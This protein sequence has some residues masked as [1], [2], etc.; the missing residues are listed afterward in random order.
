VFFSTDVSDLEPAAP[1]ATNACGGEV[2]LT[3]E[4]SA[5]Q[6]GDRCGA[7][8]DGFLTCNGVDALRCIAATPPNPCGGCGNL[9]FEPYDACGACGDGFYVCNGANGLICEAASAPNACGGCGA[10]DGAPGYPCNANALANWACVSPSEVV[11]TDGDVNPCGG[12][13]PLTFNGEEALPGDSCAGACR[14]GVLQCDGPESLVC[15]GAVAENACGG[16]SV[17]PGEL[18]ESCGP[19]G[20]Q[21]AC[22]EDGSYVCD[23]ITPN[24]CGGCESLSLQPGQACGT[25]G[26]TVCNSVD[27]VACDGGGGDSNACGGLERLD[28]TPGGVCG[29]CDSGTWV[30]TSTSTVECVGAGTVNPCFGCLPL[31]GDPGAPCGPCGSG[32]WSCDGEESVT[33]VGAAEAAADEENTCGGCGTLPGTLG[34]ECGVCHTYACFG[35]A[36]LQC[37]FDPTDVCTGGVTCDELGCERVFRECVEDVVE[38]GATASY[39]GQ[40]IDGYVEV[41]GECVPDQVC[42]SDAECPDPVVSQWS[43]CRY[44]EPCGE[45]GARQRQYVRFECRGGVCRPRVDETE[46][47]ECPPRETDGIV[48]SGVGGVPSSPPSECQ[49]T[50]VPCSEQGIRQVEQYVCRDGEPTVEFDQVECRL[51]SRDGEPCGTA[52]TCRDERCVET[53]TSGGIGTACNSDMVCGSRNCSRNVCAPQGFVTIPDGG[54][55]HGAGPLDGAGLDDATPQIVVRFTEPFF[56]SATE[57][58]WTAFGSADASCA[59]C[60]VEG[61]TLGEVLVWLNGRSELEGLE[62]CYVFDADAGSIGV[63]GRECEGYRLPNEFEWEFAARAGAATPYYCGPLASCLREAAWVGQRSTAPVGEREPNPFG[64]H[65]I[66]GNVSEWTES[67]YTEDGYRE[68]DSPLEDPDADDY[69]GSVV[70]VRGCSF[71]DDDVSACRH[72]ERSP[73]S[74]LTSR[75]SIGFRPVRSLPS[76]FRP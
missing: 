17:P 67:T 39:C 72:A 41:E 28:A 44:E 37:V 55:T 73:V 6:P 43:E 62:P 15:A 50:A 40:C 20:G 4:G 74:P 58:T 59:D 64:L 1:S 48:V 68:L 56:M 66:E 35:D 54:S 24:A 60:P 11:C 31:E 57:V 76:R 63:V 71:A 14:D 75:P 34:A 27:S 65:D 32:V 49:Q 5:Q 25:N 26:V 8:G 45:R 7:C 10:L 47:E 13:E 38:S 22:A 18:G 19:C 36:R 2:S 69:D 53:P 30:C 23:A 29:A 33:C 12:V 51:P 16:C 9:A 3:W 21:W 46:F 42:G 70:V 61:V 52:G